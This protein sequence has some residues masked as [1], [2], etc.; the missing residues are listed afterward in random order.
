MSTSKSTWKHSLILARREVW[1]GSKIM[2]WYL[3]RLGAMVAYLTGCQEYRSI[4]F[5]FD[6]SR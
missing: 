2:Q 1:P 5:L 4:G 3:Q 6:H